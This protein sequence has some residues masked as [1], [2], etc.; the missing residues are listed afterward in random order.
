MADG[1]AEQFG[2]LRGRVVA[3]ESRLDRHENSTTQAQRE[4]REEINRSMSELRGEMKGQFAEV[5][6]GMQTVQSSIGELRDYQER[7]RGS[8]TAFGT[9]GAAA[10]AIGSAL[11]GAL[12]TIFAVHPQK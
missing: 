2:E 3:L 5:K 9:I 1:I 10:L 11:I 4:L 6:V 7:Y 12:A 8:R